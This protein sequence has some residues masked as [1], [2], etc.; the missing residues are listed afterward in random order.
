MYQR[1]IPEDG[2]VE[3]SD[4]GIGKES[5]TPK[6]DKERRTRSEGMMEQLSKEAKVSFVADEGGREGLKHRAPDQPSHHWSAKY[7]GTRVR[8]ALLLL[9]LQVSLASLGS[10]RMLSFRMLCFTLFLFNTFWLIF[11]IALIY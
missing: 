4:E 6:S 7:A 3:K 1:H 8:A 11:T 2:E 10:F 9:P 5:G